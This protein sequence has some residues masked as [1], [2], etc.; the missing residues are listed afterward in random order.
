MFYLATLTRT[1]PKTIEYFLTLR[2]ALIPLCGV[3]LGIIFWRMKRPAPGQSYFYTTSCLFLLITPY[4]LSAIRGDTPFDRSFIYLTV[5]FA[6]LAAATGYEF[7]RLLRL[8]DIKNLIFLVALFAYCQASFSLALN[9]RDQHIQRDI[10]AGVMSQDIF[11]NYYQAYYFPL[12]T[13]ASIANQRDLFPVN[14]YQPG[15]AVSLIGY[16]EKYN[17]PYTGIHSTQD[18]VLNED[19]SGLFLTATPEQFVNMMEKDAPYLTCSRQ[20]QLNF[21]AVFYCKAGG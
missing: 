15:D 13:A 19:R 14:M 8:P 16:L 7:I 18:M 21:V 4:L 3:G 11:Y 10:E 5:I 1:M 17:I 6:L 2:L 12:K 20:N 9:Q